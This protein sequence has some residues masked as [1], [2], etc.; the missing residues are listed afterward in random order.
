MSL[1]SIRANVDYGI[2]SGIHEMKI[3]RGNDTLPARF[4]LESDFPE[5]DTQTGSVQ[6]TWSGCET[7]LSELNIYGTL[8]LTINLAQS[9]HAWKLIDDIQDNK[10][11]GNYGFTQGLVPTTDPTKSRV[12][13]SNIDALSAIQELASRNDGFDFDFDENKAFN[14][15]YPYSGNVTDVVFEYGRNV[16]KVSFRRLAGPGAIAN[17]VSAFG[18]TNSA[19]AVDT[20]SRDLYGLREAIVRL[21]N[22]TDVTATLQDYADAHLYTLKNPIIIP[23]ITLN[24][25]HP[26]NEWGS[27]W[28]GDIVTVRAK[29]RGGEYVNINDEYQIIGITIEIN[30]MGTETISVD[31]ASILPIAIN[32]AMIDLIYSLENPNT[33]TVATQKNITQRISEIEAALSVG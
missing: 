5:L 1:D 21:P 32:R 8:P 12:Y 22:A 18:N 28:L 23:K 10:T 14:C 20:T 9:A 24:S 6:L 2:Q 25:I 11:G 29:Y 30:D 7:Y 4:R 15:Y 13:D 26:G 27:F 33:T 31:L 16:E 17:S 3:I 19:T